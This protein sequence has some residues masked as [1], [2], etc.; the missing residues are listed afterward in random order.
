MTSALGI[1]HKVRL[2]EKVRDN[3]EGMLSIPCPRHGCT[4][5]V[6]AFLTGHPGAFVPGGCPHH[7]WRIEYQ[8]CVDVLADEYVSWYREWKNEPLPF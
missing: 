4:G 3:G 5:M 2:L 7:P 1:A 6:T 8:R